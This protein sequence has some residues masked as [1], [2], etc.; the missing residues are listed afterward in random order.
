MGWRLSVLGLTFS[1]LGGC[2]SEPTLSTLIEQRQVVE[3][4]A[5]GRFESGDLVNAAQNFRQAAQLAELADNRVALVTNLVNLGAVEHQLGNHDAGLLAYERALRLAAMEQR[6]DMELRAIAG[7]AEINYGQ[8]NRDVAKEL[9]Q[10][11]I[12]HPAARGDSELQI[13]AL[14]GLALCLLDGNDTDAAARY[15][16]RAEALGETPPRYSTAPRWSCV[17]ANWP[18]P[19]RLHA[20]RSNSIGPAVMFL[21]L[22]AIW[23]C[24]GS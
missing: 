21:G 19:K 3:Q 5:L 13:M 4:R 7:L 6:A 11:L 15:L 9:Y 10:Q 24:W 20:A 23:K 18:A 8:G 17:V 16:A 14:N 2:A 1:L 22:P 12:D